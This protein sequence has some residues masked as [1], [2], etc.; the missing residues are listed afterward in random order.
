MGK[1]KRSFK[2]QGQ[3]CVY[4]LQCQDNTFYTGH[5]NDLARRLKQHN[6]KKGAWYTKFK[7]P[8]ELVWSKKYSYFKPAFMAEQRIKKLTRKQKETLVAGKRLESVFK[9]AGK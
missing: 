8:V 9:E 1:D 3:F 2:R 5:T 7:T 4:I 6:S